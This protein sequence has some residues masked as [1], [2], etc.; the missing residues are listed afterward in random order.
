M[1]QPIDW[2]SERERAYCNLREGEKN[3]ISSFFLIWSYFESQLLDCRAGR[4][5]FENLAA[6]LDQN[7]KTKD[8]NLDEYVKYFQERYVDNG[9]LN[10]R[11]DYLHMEESNNPEEVVRMLLDNECSDK[12]KIIGCLFIVY[13]YR[14]NLFHGPKW[15]YLLSEQQKN[16]E[17]S[18]RLLI[19]IMDNT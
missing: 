15:K 2:L 5:K 13:R 12:I 14:N 17:N 1:I 11:F 6:L 19:K 8:I 18:S 3:A 4:R 16:M 7:D 10:D 9:N